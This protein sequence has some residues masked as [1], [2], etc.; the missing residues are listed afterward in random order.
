M[1]ISNKRSTALEWSVLNYL[2]CLNRFNAR[3]TVVGYKHAS[4]LVR[5]KEAQ[6]YEC[7]DTCGFNHSCIKLF[8]SHL[9]ITYIVIMC[10]KQQ[11]KHRLGM[12]NIELLR[13]LIPV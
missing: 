7:N 1:I 6:I 12:V 10:N 2:G 11:Q 5:L 9:L 3:E 4:Y 13:K 8:D